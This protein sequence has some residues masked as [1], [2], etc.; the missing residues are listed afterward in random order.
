MFNVYLMGGPGDGKFV[1]TKDYCIELYKEI[2]GY[3]PI[4]VQYRFLLSI[5]SFAIY[6][7]EDMTQEE[8]VEIIAKRVTGNEFENGYNK[9]LE[10]MQSEC[11]NFGIDTNRVLSFI[12][13]L[14]EKLNKK[15]EGD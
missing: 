11:L 1:N 5:L 8:A 9:C 13:S 14:K 10:D 7:W 12:Y 3:K 2:E 6:I 4:K 15:T